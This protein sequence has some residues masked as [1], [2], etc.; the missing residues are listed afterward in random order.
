MM[1]K[2]RS[3]DPRDSSERVLKVVRLR[4]RGITK[5]DDMYDWALLEME[6][7]RVAYKGE[8]TYFTK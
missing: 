5:I 7:L 3:F 4:G 8:F 6:L 2:I 1:A